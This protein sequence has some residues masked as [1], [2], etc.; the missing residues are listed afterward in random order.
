M[1]DEIVEYTT[2]T[3]TTV[4]GLESVQEAVLTSTMSVKYQLPL[5]SLQ[6]VTSTVFRRDSGS[7]SLP[8]QSEALARSHSSN[9]SHS[10]ENVYDTNNRATAF[11]STSRIKFNPDDPNQGFPKP[12]DFVTVVSVGGTNQNE[13]SHNILLAGSSHANEDC[14]DGRRLV[15]QSFHPSMKLSKEDD[16]HHQGTN[17]KLNFAPTHSGENNSGERYEKSHTDECY[18][19]NHSSS[20]N[21]R[22]DSN[23]EKII[24]FSESEQPSFARIVPRNICEKV[25]V[26]R[27]PGEKLGLGLKFDGGWGCRDLVRRLFIESIALDSPGYRASLPWGQLC[28]G[29]Q[30]LN[31]EGVPVSSMT[32]LQCVTALRDSHVRVT[33]GV[34]RGDGVVPLLED[35]PSSVNCGQG[36]RIGLPPPPLPPRHFSSRDPGRPPKDVSSFNHSA[37]TE[38]IQYFVPDNPAPPLPPAACVYMDLL[39]EEEERRKRCGSESDETGSSV[40]TVIDRLSLTSSTNVS[41][42]SSFNASADNRYNQ[43]DLTSALSQFEML[44]QEFECDTMPRS[45]GHNSAVNETYPN[46]TSS[47]QRRHLVRSFSLSPGTYKDHFNKIQRKKDELSRTS[48]PAIKS[49][50]FSLKRRPFSWTPLINSNSAHKLNSNGSADFCCESSALKNNCDEE[51]KNENPSG[52]GNP[53]YNE[54]DCMSEESTSVEST[55]KISSG[56][57]SCS[58]PP[59]AE[60]VDDEETFRRNVPCD[61]SP[62]NDLNDRTSELGFRR[63]LVFTSSHKNNHTPDSFESASPTQ[64]FISNDDS[65]ENEPIST[66]LECN[67]V[68]GPEIPNHQINVLSFSSSEFSLSPHIAEQVQIETPASICYDFEQASLSSSDAAG[69]VTVQNMIADSPLD[70]GSQVFSPITVNNLH[71][72][73]SSANNKVCQLTTESHCDSSEK[74][75]VEAQRFEMEHNSSGYHTENSE[76]VE[77]TST[78]VCTDFVPDLSTTT[79][80]LISSPRVNNE[81]HLSRKGCRIS[82]RFREIADDFY[83]SIDELNKTNEEEKI[84][85]KSRRDLEFK[86]RKPPHL[87]VHESQTSMTTLKSDA[88]EDEHKMCQN[89]REDAS[90]AHDTQ[91]KNTNSSSSSSLAKPTFSIDP[92]KTKSADADH[93]KLP[94]NVLKYEATIQSVAPKSKSPRKSENSGSGD[95]VSVD[96]HTTDTAS[97]IS[98]SDPS[99]NHTE[100][101]A[102]SSTLNAPVLTID[103]KLVAAAEN[104]YVAVECLS[105]QVLSTDKIVKLDEQCSTSVECSTSQTETISPN[106][107]LNSLERSPP[108]LRLSQVTRST[109]IRED[110]CDLIRR[111]LERLRKDLDLPEGFELQVEEDE[112]VERIMEC[113]STE[114]A[115]RIVAAFRSNNDRFRLQPQSL[116]AD[117]SERLSSPEE[118]MASL[119]A[120]PTENKCLASSKCQK[121]GPN[122]LTRRNSSLTNKDFLQLNSISSFSS[123]K[124]P[125]A[126]SSS[127]HSNTS[128]IFSSSH[129]SP[130]SVD[131]VQR[132]PRESL[133]MMHSPRDQYNSEEEWSYEY[134]QER[135][136]GTIEEESASEDGKSDAPNVL[137][138]AMRSLCRSRTIPKDIIVSPP[139]PEPESTSTE[140]LLAID[141]VANI[142]EQNKTSNF[143]LST[144]VGRHTSESDKGAKIDIRP[145]FVSSSEAFY[146]KAPSKEITQLPC[147]TVDFDSSA[148]SSGDCSSTD[149]L[150]VKNNIEI[151]DNCD[152]MN[153]QSI[154]VETNSSA[155]AKEQVLSKTDVSGELKINE[156]KTM[157]PSALI[158][159]SNETT[160]ANLL[161]N[162]D[163]VYLGSVASKRSLIDTRSQCTVGPGSNRRRPPCRIG[164]RRT[165]LQSSHSSV[166][167]AVVE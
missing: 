23:C 143:D 75:I 135:P 32:R 158:N 155:G 46:A 30:I 79:S 152:L 110:L 98:N 63:K 50:S 65:L 148:P 139:T 13:V 84:E 154:Y 27:L 91:E 74:S 160:A 112:E 51:T 17:R 67:R 117:A 34:L 28:P 77:T 45:S 10:T 47:K 16:F 49:L 72:H 122:G 80:L 121:L 20:S 44:E 92:S 144:Q 126:S 83:R 70:N 120:L 68:E 11:N 102:S 159:A 53:T 119:P 106:Q 137:L 115:D 85:L 97:N 41:R 87:N 153:K 40:S 76:L 21:R 113:D 60:I 52:T 55:I 57:R 6:P 42:N 1:C 132:L 59:A 161:V 88:R 71:L 166:L 147:T 149:T 18:S 150:L 19:P 9:L 103:G 94:S 66:K 73:S 99:S 4:S 107:S 36:D 31:I 118:S 116:P 114:E 127:Y 131:I 93:L 2:T 156:R 90:A 167:V 157:L 14:I 140:N 61:S 33:I 5:A 165:S 136:C 100:S 26:L 162:D 56:E 105:S 25:V 124:L 58:P 89:T 129:S 104:G 108:T 134:Y 22:E 130:A 111:D 109:R 151:G 29:D 138:N 123:S 101:H 145:A 39:V 163:E 125:N 146:A 62:K 141:L 15:S 142:E 24:S 128:S 3:S 82:D 78:E 43:I 164:S 7:Q 35:G 96:L 8:Y 48:K 38:P 69:A 12:P 95:G 37:K 86:A 81:S 133:P 54:L 64:V